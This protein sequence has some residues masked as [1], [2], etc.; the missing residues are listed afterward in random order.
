ML[1]CG[2]LKALYGSTA[3]DVTDT[4]AKQFCKLGDKVTAILLLHALSL[5]LGIHSSLFSRCFSGLKLGCYKQN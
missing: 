3:L 4:L 1:K 2:C 5:I